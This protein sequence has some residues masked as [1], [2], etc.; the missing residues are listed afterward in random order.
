M[1]RHFMPGFFPAATNAPRTRNVFLICHGNGGNISH[2]LGLYEVLLQTGA[3]IF[4]FDYR[5]YGRSTGRPDEEGT[6][7]DAQSAFQWLRQKGFAPKNIIAYGESLGGGVASE[8]A[9]RET[10]GGLILQST[11][12]STPDIGA[13][14]FPWLPV[15]RVSRIKYDTRSKLPKI[16]APILIIHSRNDSLVRFHH[17]QENFAAANEPKTLLEIHGD[18]NDGITDPS[19]FLEGLNRFLAQIHAP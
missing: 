9:M 10:I 4:A 11:F 1:A 14:L 16:R 6:Y 3:G 19:H 5:G 8:L 15:R 13:E 7:R 18:H 17:A 2:R 12:T